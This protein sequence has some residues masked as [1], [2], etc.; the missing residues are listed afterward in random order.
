MKTIGIKAVITLER[1]LYIEVEEDISDEEVQS[2]AEKEIV[3][4]TNALA[5]AN[6]A[7]A[8]MGIKINGLDLTDWEVK[9]YEYRQLE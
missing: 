4:P 1:V 9:N 3:L 7:L 5:L 6:N 2:R 8:K